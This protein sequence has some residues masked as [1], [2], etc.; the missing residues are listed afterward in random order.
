MTD[1]MTEFF[2]DVPG[3]PDHPDF[4]KLSAI[5]L[6]MDADASDTEGFEKAVAHVDPRSLTY[7]AMQRAQ[8]TYRG[9]N[10][11]AILAI[12]ATWLDGFIAGSRWQS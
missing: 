4:W 1:A 5:L 12:A 7:T 3:R 11:D 10:P 9:D 2:G 6:G 8:R